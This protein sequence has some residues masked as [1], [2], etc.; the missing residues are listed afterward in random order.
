MSC[1]KNEGAFDKKRRCV[2]KKRR[3]GHGECVRLRFLVKQTHSR[4]HCIYTGFRMDSHFFLSPK[5]FTG[6]EWGPDSG[7]KKGG[8][9]FVNTLY[10]CTYVLLYLCTY[11][12]ICLFVCLFICLFI[13]LFVPSYMNDIVK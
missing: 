13:Y 9:R 2:W 4:S 7:S 11:V 8:P 10:L 5:K 12:F 3:Q 1:E 6:P